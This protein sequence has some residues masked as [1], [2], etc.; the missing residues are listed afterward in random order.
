MSLSSYVPICD[1]VVLLMKPFVEIVI[2]EIQTNQI[3]YINGTLSKRQVGDS[4]LLDTQALDD[5]KQ[6]VYSKLN[7]D[8]K[9]VKSV[10]VVLENKWLLCINCDVSAF[11]KMQE[12][13]SIFLNDVSS[14]QPKSLFVNDWQQKVNLSVHDYIEIHNLSF[15]HL[16]ISD[17]K[18]IVQYLFQLG[19]FA[20]KNAADYIAKTLDL[21]RATVFKYLKELKGQE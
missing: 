21:G 2:H 20:E 16:K 13:S 15:S 10:S 14:S 19:A 18:K 4:S 11:H 9:L 3:V 8:G 17:K 7:F 6:A 12:I 1:A 5:V